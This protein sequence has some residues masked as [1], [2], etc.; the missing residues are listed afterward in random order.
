MESIFFTQE[1]TGRGSQ[2]FT[3]YKVRTMTGACAG[4]EPGLGE[5]RVTG[6]YPEKH[7]VTSLGA[8][9]R[10]LGIDEIPQ[11]YNILRGEMQFIG[12]RP[13]LEE[14][15]DFFP[16]DIKAFYIA[17]F[18]GLFP[19]DLAMARS[20]GTL[21]NKYAAMRMF[22]EEVRKLEEHPVLKNRLLF[23]LRII[24]CSVYHRYT[25]KE[26]IDLICE[27]IL[28]NFSGL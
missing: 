13:V 12:M 28:G 2:P 21:K 20:N 6:R 22:M 3:L 8:I 11:L 5:D 10:Y 7:R 19:G 27:K 1:R 14:D 24:F 16:E 26:H 25:D 18:P 17:H 4:N 23:A 9:L 15:V